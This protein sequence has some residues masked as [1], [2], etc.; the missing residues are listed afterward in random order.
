MNE[1]CQLKP[2]ETNQQEKEIQEKLKVELGADDEV[3]TPA[4][5]IDLLSNDSIIEIKELGHPI[6][7]RRRF[8]SIKGPKN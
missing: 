4:G 5:F 1:L 7:K 3:E 8:K 2:Y 6:K